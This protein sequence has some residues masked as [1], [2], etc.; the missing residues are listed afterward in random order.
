MKSIGCDRLDAGRF[1]PLHPSFLQPSCPFFFFK[2]EGRK[3][4]WEGQL[5]WVWNDSCLLSNHFLLWRGLEKLALVY[6]VGAVQPTLDWAEQWSPTYRIWHCADSHR[7]INPITTFFSALYCN[8]CCCS[9]NSIERP[10]GSTTYTNLLS[11]SLWDLKINSP[12]HFLFQNLFT[13]IL[14]LKNLSALWHFTSQDNALP[15]DK[16]QKADSIV[17]STQAM[18][19]LCHPSL[20]ENMHSH[21]QNLPKASNFLCAM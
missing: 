21:T 15:E 16:K 10:Q 12:S 18:L 19:L 3:S 6:Y 8:L 4:E 13:K 7:E 17:A 2:G 1:R 11:V 5:E 14:K 9:R 20:P